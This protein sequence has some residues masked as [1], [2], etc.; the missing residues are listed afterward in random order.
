[1]PVI[2]A[3]YYEK[4]DQEHVKCILC[5]QNCHIRPDKEGL[6]RVRFNDGGT[7]Y[8]RNY[9]EVASLALD[10]VEKKPLYHFY[11]GRQILSVGTWGCNLSCGF[12][13]NYSLA[14][15][16]VPT[17]VIMPETLVKIA[18][19]AKADNSIGIAFTYNEPSIWFEYI[20]E[21]AEKMKAQGLKTVLVTNGYMEKAPLTR[22]LPFI[23]AANVDVK[24]FTESFYHRN[25]KGRLKEVKENVEYMAGK[26]HLE[27]T[28]LIIPDEN[29]D[30]SEIEA[31]AVWLAS[32][33]PDIPLHL[34]R[35]HPAY[36]MHRDPTEVSTMLKAQE[37]CRQHLN[38]VYLGNLPG[39]NNNTPC[40]ECG[41]VL[42]ARNVYN[43]KITGLRDGK[44]SYCG[45][46]I[47]Y[48]T[49]G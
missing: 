23:D 45:A 10:P 2:E 24:A 19:Q 12:C 8:T 48:I 46:G 26:I 13:Q 35:Y 21:T 17:R 4:L 42:I 34:S 28:N 9:A 49:V 6:C 38:F 3:Q 16:K 33:D 7:L 37:I 44:C 5:P 40:L 25:C 14:R 39:I 1:M 18:R 31:M 43:V 27:I 11:P 30:P 22:L 47:E 29:D 36:K 15:Q 32:I 41:Q 20:L